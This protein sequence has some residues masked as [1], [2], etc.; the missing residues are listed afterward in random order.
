MP[1]LL[2]ACIVYATAGTGLA[3]DDFVHLG[4]ALTGNW[5]RD[6]LPRAYLSVPILHYTHAAAYF[7]FGDHLWAYALLKAIYLSFALWGTVRLFRIFHP[8]RVAWF[9]AAAFCLNPVHDAAT[10]WFTGQYLILSV[11]LYFHAYATTHAGK[12]GQGAMLAGLGSFTSYGSPP[13]A[14]G[15]TL[16]FAMQR[17]WREAAAMALPNTA[18]VAYYLWTSIYLKAG[19]QRLPTAFDPL[20]L[21]KY[22]ALQVASFVD[23]GIGPSAW[24]KFSLALS[25]LSWCSTLIAIGAAVLAWRA[26]PSSAAG[27]R[28]HPLLA[29]PLLAGA[30]TIALCAFAVFALTGSYP[31][32]AFNLGD[33]VTIYGNL[34]VA[35]LSMQLLGARTLAVFGAVTLAAFIGTGDHWKGWA[36]DVRASTARINAQGGFDAI[37]PDDVVFVQGLQYSQLGRISHIDHFASGYV[38]REVFSLARPWRTPIATASFNHR[39]RLAGDTLIDEKYGDRWQLKDAIWLYDA[40]SG[41]LERVPLA[42]IPARLSALPPDLRHWTQLLGPGMVR[43]A[44]LWMMPAVRYAYS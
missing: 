32:L 43:D 18:Y 41:T 33:R 1:V 29:D 30:L 7:A 6:W 22:Y 11:G 14:A 38:V 10:L 9:G 23:A 27:S 15:L 3:T 31:Q 4:N 28:A 8:A 25:S 34:L 5:S 13:L 24:L 35:V 16:M 17:R 20:A 21:I 36:V 12:I 26:R 39:L 37:G 44:I 19:T 42:R 40:S 2:F